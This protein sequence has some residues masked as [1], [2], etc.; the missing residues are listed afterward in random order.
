[1]NIGKV[2]VVICTKDVHQI[3]QK[4]LDILNN[5]GWVN[6]IIIETSKPLAIARIRATE[7]CVTKWIAMFDDDVEIPE[8]WF[9]KVSS[10]ITSGILA[11]STPDLSLIPDYLA[12]Q[13]LADK[14]LKL[15][16]RDTPFIDNVLFR[17]DA[18][19]GYSP[20][21]AFYCEDEFFYEHVKTK[22]KW[23]HLAPIGVRHFYIEKDA[24]YSG[25]SQRIYKFEPIYVLLR[26][27][28]VRFFLAPFLTVFYTHTVRTV[29]RWWRINVRIMAGWLIAYSIREKIGVYQIEVKP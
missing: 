9:D 10:V 5:A 26:R 20:A 15:S 23:I 13:L 3:R 22:G 17:K 21:S 18:L 27:T 29:W 24:L 28:L 16:E 2:D 7:K 14:I 6:T 25:A 4:L 12:M 11:V 19:E 1:V 8:D